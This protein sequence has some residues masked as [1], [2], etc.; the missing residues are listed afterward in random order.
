MGRS[1]L[2]VTEVVWA[3]S[4][5]YCVVEGGKSGFGGLAVGAVWERLC[6]ASWGFGV[7]RCFC[8]VGGDGDGFVGGKR[9]VDRFFVYTNRAGWVRM[10]RRAWKKTRSEKK[11][12][13]PLE[14]SLQ[15]STIV[16]SVDGRFFSRLVI[17]RDVRGGCGGV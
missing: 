17:L 2:Y 1:G 4:E 5:R 13:N 12:M 14:T 6:G 15:A 7:W 11:Q 8:V 3:W 10:W 9:W 16:R